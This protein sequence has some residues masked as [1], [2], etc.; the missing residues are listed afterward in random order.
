MDSQ[1][2]FRLVT[3]NL[4]LTFLLAQTLQDGLAKIASILSAVSMVLFFGALIYCGYSIATGRIEA[5]K[6]GL[7][8]AG[9][10]ALAWVLTK[11]L[12]DAAGGINPGDLPSF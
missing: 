6:P 1:R 10:G 4:L 9:I 7:L 8:G 5:L 11:A 2:I 3:M 12:F